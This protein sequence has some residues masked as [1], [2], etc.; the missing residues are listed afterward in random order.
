LDDANSFL[1]IEYHFYINDDHKHDSYFVQHYLQK[2]WIYMVEEVYAPSIHFVWSDG[3]ASQF[4]SHKPWYFVGH[5]PN[6][7]SGC[8][9][10]WSFFGMGHGKGA[11]DGPRVVIKWFLW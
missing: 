9:M 5:Y 10:I 11:H 3:Y 2:H 7:T 6:L 8:A 1:I 4:K